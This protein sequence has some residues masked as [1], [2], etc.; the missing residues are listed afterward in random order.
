MVSKTA[1][2]LLLLHRRPGSY[3]DKVRGIQSANLIGYWP[4]NETT[5]TNAD[6]AE[7]TAARDGTYTGVTLNSVTGPDGVNG[8]PFFDGIS[9]FVDIYS[10]SLNA[11]WNAPAAGSVAIWSRPSGVGVYTDGSERR[12]L[13]VRIDASNRLR[14]M[15]SAN[16]NQID[17]IYTGG[18]T[19]D[20]VSKTSFSDTDWMHW[21]ITWDTVADE[22]KA[23]FNGVQE[24]ATQTVI[25]TLVGNLSAALTNVGS[26]GQ[27]SVVW[28]GYL[29]HPA[30]WTAVLTPLEILDL[31]TV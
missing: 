23:Y 5:G 18:G 24:G 1:R 10:A 28:D 27:P 9:D 19:L 4:L 22:M 12:K 25:G 16:N 3:I 14:L 13:T 7:G 11:A 2:N 30:L 26:Q 15:K 21:V 20:S 6:N 17:M 31:A 8:A 29:A